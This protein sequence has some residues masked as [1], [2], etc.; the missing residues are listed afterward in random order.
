MIDLGK[1]NELA[2]DVKYYIGNPSAWERYDDVISE[3]IRSLVS[4]IEALA[5]LEKPAE[6][7]TEYTAEDQDFAD[8]LYDESVDI[9]S[10]GVVCSFN[11]ELAAQKIHQYAESCHAKKCA[12]IIAQRNLLI[13]AIK[14]MK[15]DC[16]ISSHYCEICGSEDSMK[17]FDIYLRLEEA[18]LIVPEA[19]R[20]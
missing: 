11:L 15:H 13:K 9:D 3:K 2:S 6:N 4:E 5:E 18:L 1:V 8:E 16:D 19:P 7:G 20:A 14:E 12:E 10:D 17:N